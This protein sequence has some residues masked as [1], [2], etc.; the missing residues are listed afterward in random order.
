M[1]AVR[2]GSRKVLWEKHLRAREPADRFPGTGSGCPRKRRWRSGAGPAST[3]GGLRTFVLLVNLR[4]R[5]CILREAF[6][7]L[8]S[9]PAWLQ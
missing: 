9:P 4:G 8:A 7:F 1:E 6:C 3:R 5:P 2:V